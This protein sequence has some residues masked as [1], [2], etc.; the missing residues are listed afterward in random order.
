MVRKED[1]K[2]LP[3]NLYLEGARYRYRNPKGGERH[4]F[5]TG[6][7]KA[8]ALNAAIELN[9]KLVGMTS[10]VAKILG[11]PMFKHYA[12]EYLSRTKKSKKKPSTKKIIRNFVTQLIKEFDR[13]MAEI[14]LEDISNFL[15]NQTG[16]M[17][18]QYRTRL[19][20][21]YRIPVAKGAV[22]ENLPG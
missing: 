22:P 19:M 13:P 1:N 5:P 12:K 18:R 10:I 15:D 8:E 9:T 6:M 16:D 14:T 2:D 21:I 11:A 3:K 17:A 20:A 7:S 4:W